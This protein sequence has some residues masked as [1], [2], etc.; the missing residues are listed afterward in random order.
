MLAVLVTHHR[1]PLFDFTG[2]GTPS[3]PQDGGLISQPLQDV[4]MLD[5]PWLPKITIRQPHVSE[6]EPRRAPD[7]L[8]E[9]IPQQ[10]LNRQTLQH[11]DEN[12][13][14]DFSFLHFVTMA[15]FLFRT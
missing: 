11:L 6:S 12:T 4:T 3:T 8:R 9:L 10:S 7:G 5:A 1:W 14:Y 2:A 15:N 13:H